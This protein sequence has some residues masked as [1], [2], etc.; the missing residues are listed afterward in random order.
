MGVKS[1]YSVWQQMLDYFDASPIGLTSMPDKYT[2]AF[3]AKLW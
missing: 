2:F 1:I 3:G